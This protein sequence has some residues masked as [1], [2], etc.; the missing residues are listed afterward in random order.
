MSRSA[1]KSLSIQAV[2][3]WTTQ[4]MILLVQV[5]YA[6][7]SSRIIDPTG[8]GSYAVALSLGSFAGIIAGLGLATATARRGPTD[9]AEQQGLCAAALASGMAMAACMALISGLWSQIWRDPQASTLVQCL[10]IGMAVTPYSSVLNSVLRRQGRILALNI[11]TGVS[12]VAGIVLGAMALASFDESWTLTVMPVTT[13]VLATLGQSAAVGAAARPRWQYAL[14]RQDISFGA[15]SMGTALVATTSYALPQ[16]AMSRTLGVGVLGAWNRAVVVG[17]LPWE[18]AVRAVL[19]VVFPRFPM[20]GKPLGVAR[21][22][23]TDLLVVIAFGIWPI[24]AWVLPAI[25]A[26]TTTWLGDTWQLAGQMAAWLWLIAGLQASRTVLASLLES[27]AEFRALLIGEGI[28][29]GS[30]LF[31]AA[32]LVV[33]HTWQAMAACIL[34][35][36]ILSHGVHAIL[37]AGLGFVSGPA[38]GRGYL[39]AF[40]VALPVGLVS[41]SLCAQL[42]PAAQIICAAGGGLSIAV[43]LFVFRL[44]IGPT[45][46]LL[47]DPQWVREPHP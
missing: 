16:F 36:V 45:S 19:T 5:F 14:I 44:R 30:M 18:S 28:T 39:Q 43:G 41:A 35:G 7:F 12:A 34:G 20:T 42:S 11:I 32:L 13:V 4:L 23:R 6:G 29:A 17:Q 26:V 31:G 21:Q 46:R 37:G 15:K 10:A 33:T 27:S 3:V 25:P 47:G 9:L 2:S 24:T 8:F 38:L 1:A 40:G 22:I